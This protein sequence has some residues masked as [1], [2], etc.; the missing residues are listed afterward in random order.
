M[1]T[2]T[3]NSNSTTFRHLTWKEA[4]IKLRQTVECHLE[5]RPS[6]YYSQQCSKGKSN[7]AFLQHFDLG[8]AL[9]A[10]LVLFLLAL[11]SY[12]E[13]TA[14]FT[15]RLSPEADAYVYVTE[16]TGSILAVSAA[17]TSLLVVWARRRASGC[18]RH[19]GVRRALRSFS[20]FL[21]SEEQCEKGASANATGTS[22]PKHDQ[23]GAEISNRIDLSSGTTL[24]DIYPVYRSNQWHQVPSL[25]LVEGDVI[26]MQVGDTS[27]ALLE[28]ILPRSSRSLQQ[29]SAQVIVQADE[30]ITPETYSGSELSQP[31]GKQRAKDEGSIPSLPK[32][33]LIRSP[34]SKDLLQLCND[35]RIFQI[36]ETPLK[37]FLN[38]AYCE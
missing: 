32:G 14:K 34:D 23:H 21:K 35:L 5:S 17:S 16:I 37:R 11:L 4:R 36:K 20:S 8:F 9:F 30:K 2:T 22:S 1:A 6:K 29:Q 27:P 7:W 25:L 12:L 28:E 31:D 10:S 18:N 13:R 3:P 19:V 33:K 24:T 38:I 26:A 15:G